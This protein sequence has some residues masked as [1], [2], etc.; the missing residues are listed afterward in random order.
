MGG[1]D[2]DGESE[3]HC[4]VLCCLMP[5]VFASIIVGAILWHRRQEKKA[6]AD[7]QA[8]PD[9]GPRWS[10][11][12]PGDAETSEGIQPAQNDMTER[13]TTSD[14]DQDK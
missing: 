10:E 8:L 13:P 6:A 5:L 4:F 14:E 11:R 9:P 7:E 2:G 1:L 12:E 3:Q